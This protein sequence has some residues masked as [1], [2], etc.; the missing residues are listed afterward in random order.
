MRRGRAGSVVHMKLRDA[1]LRV[2]WLMLLEF[3]FSF[4]SISR[5]FDANIWHAYP[6]PCEGHQERKARCVLRLNFFS[7]VT[8]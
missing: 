8:F 7:L 6:T 4:F 5:C 2:N 1:N 3:L